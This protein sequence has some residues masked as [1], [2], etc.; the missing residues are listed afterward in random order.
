MQGSFSFH[1]GSFSASPPHSH[2]P[3]WYVPTPTRTLCSVLGPARRVCARL[4]GFISL[5]SGQLLINPHTPLSLSLS[6]STLSPS[7]C[8]QTSYTDKGEKPTEGRYLGFDH[9][10]FWVGNAKQGPRFFNRCAVH[11]PA[12][13]ASPASPAAVSCALPRAA[14][15]VCALPAAQRCCFRCFC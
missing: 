2:N 11:R 4:C 12:S 3:S 6:P 13:P 15:A 8:L 10:T 5:W 14:R 9:A 7:R 1:P